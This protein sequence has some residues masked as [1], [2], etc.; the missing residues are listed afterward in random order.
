[1]AIVGALLVGL[2]LS[3]IISLING[4]GTDFTIIGK[5]N[6]IK[7]YK[8]DMAELTKRIHQLELENTKLKAETNTRI[9]NKSL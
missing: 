4:I 8:K 2:F 9:D 3:W 6:K 7:N 1:M 5:E